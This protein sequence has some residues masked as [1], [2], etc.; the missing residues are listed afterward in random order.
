MGKRKADCTQEEWEKEL[1]RKRNSYRT[2]KTTYQVRDSK[3][4]W[5]KP[6]EYYVTKYGEEEG[7]RRYDKAQFNYQR[8]GN[9]TLTKYERAKRLC[10]NY[11][12]KDKKYNRETTI[13]PQW[14]VD[15]IF[16]G[17][18]CF[19]CNESDWKKL[20]VDRVNS[21]IGHIPTNCTP[22]CL[23]C[24]NHKQ[25]KPITEILNEQ[26]KTFDLFEGLPPHIVR[27][28]KSVN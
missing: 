19:Y 11:T 2:N 23:R 16:S 21:S 25:N 22:C 1:L 12:S 15:N 17:Q 8:I 4:D 20:G 18:R 13:T 7:K 27:L 9:T 24:N 3:R 26:P 10:Q 5:R 14:I 28:L 6:L